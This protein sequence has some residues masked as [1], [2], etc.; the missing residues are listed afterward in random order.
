MDAFTEGA[1]QLI[2]RTLGLQEAD[3]LWRARK[4][5]KQNVIWREM[6]PSIKAARLLIGIIASPK[7]AHVGAAVASLDSAGLVDV[8]S[9][10]SIGAPV[11][12][13]DRLLLDIIDNLS[14]R[15]P[16]G[17]IPQIARI[18]E[19]SDGVDLSSCELG[20]SLSPAAPC[21]YI[22][23]ILSDGRAVS[24]GYQPPQAAPMP[25][26]KPLVSCNCVVLSA[27]A[28]Y[29][30]EQTGRRRLKAIRLAA[31]EAPSSPTIH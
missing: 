16:P 24:F 15:T 2:A 17:L 10:Q 21:A 11:I 29:V 13:Q 18:I 27:L 20:L 4:L 26:L 9:G 8:Y 7:P 19:D 14:Q 31:S 3:A 1:A 5:W 23:A 12:E 28:S 30:G 25:A 22:A 6:L